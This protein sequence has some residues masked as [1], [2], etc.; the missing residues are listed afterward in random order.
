MSAAGSLRTVKAVHTIVW[1]IFAACILA[2]P[3]FAWLDMYRYVAWLSGIVFVEII[4]LAVRDV[5]RFFR[6]RRAAVPQPIV[7]IVELLNWVCRIRSARTV[8]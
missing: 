4:T 7:Q 3:V 6:V 1:A 5:A 8:C 2:I